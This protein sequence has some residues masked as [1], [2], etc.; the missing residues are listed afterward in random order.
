MPEI[1]RLHR[2][3]P[4]PMDGCPPFLINDT[5]TFGDASDRT[6]QAQLAALLASFLAIFLVRSLEAVL[7]TWLPSAARGRQR[8]VSRWASESGLYR[9]REAVTKD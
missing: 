8:R 9:G 7:D 3:R 1:F 5:R 6:W 2:K 4:R